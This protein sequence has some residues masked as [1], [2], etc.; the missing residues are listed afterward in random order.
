ML[1]SLPPT[2]KDR[3]QSQVF[4]HL[5]TPKPKPRFIFSDKSSV[6]DT[7]ESYAKE[8]FAHLM[9]NQAEFPYQFEKQF[10]SKVDLTKGPI[11]VT[12]E[13]YS[14]TNGSRLGFTKARKERGT[15]ITPV[16]G[17]PKTA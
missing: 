7:Y 5:K 13:K 9:S 16:P 15:C 1:F 6:I 4:R 11:L 12:V 2:H 17:R 14:Q 8:G 3:C 10:L